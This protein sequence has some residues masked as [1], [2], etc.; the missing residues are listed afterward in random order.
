MYCEN[1]GNQLKVDVHFCT[2][3]GFEVP[4]GNAFQKHK[5]DAL[6]YF[7]SIKPET[8]RVI[9]IS[10]VVSIIINIIANIF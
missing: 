5:E 2:K 9:I 8:W 3:C 1:C 7:R 10:A 4:E 6:V